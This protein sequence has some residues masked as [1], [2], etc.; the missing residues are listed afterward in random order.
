[1]RLFLGTHSRAREEK[2]VVLKKRKIGARL[3]FGPLL[4]H[5][6]FVEEPNR[7]FELEQSLRSEFGEDRPAAWNQ[8]PEDLKVSHERSRKGHVCGMIE[9]HHLVLKSAQDKIDSGDYILVN[10]RML[11]GIRLGMTE[12]DY[13]YLSEVFFK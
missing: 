10:K 1:M 5:E 6:F 11:H 3:I 8:K 12:D 13:R 2:Q 7:F 4:E 9:V